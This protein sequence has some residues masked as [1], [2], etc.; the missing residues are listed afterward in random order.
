MKLLRENIL[1]VVLAAIV[2]LGGGGMVAAY[3]KTSGSVD[4]GVRKRVQMV[5]QLRDLS[6]DG[7]NGEMVERAEKSLENIRTAAKDV[8]TLCVGWNRRNYQV[9]QLRIPDSDQTVP[10]FPYDNETYRDHGLGYV[11]SRVYV[12]AMQDLLNSLNPTSPPTQA[13]TESQVLQWEN[14]LMLQR[15]MEA[16]GVDSWGGASGAVPP[17][18]A[19]QA[20]V[21]GRRSAM[22]NKAK[23]GEVYVDPN[24]LDMVF[25]DAVLNPM[26]DQLWQAQLNLWVTRDIVAAINATNKEAFASAE[27]Q[28][29]GRNVLTAAVKRLVQVRVNENYV[30]PSVQTEAVAAPTDGGAYP[31]EAP[32]IEAPDIGAR[33]TGAGPDA[34]AAADPL[35][36]RGSSR[37]YDVLHY[38]FS[39]VMPT[40]YL[41]ALERNL[42]AQNYHTILKVEFRPPGAG[43]GPYGMEVSETGGQAGSCYYGV[44]PV[45]QVDI[46][47]ELLLLTAW[48]RGTWDSEKQKFSDQ[49]PPLVPAE[50]LARQFPGADNPALREVD[51]SRLP[52]EPAPEYGYGGDYTER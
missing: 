21:L 42:M 29:S 51:T 19:Q 37:E 43:T 45:V 40:R 23:A 50:V 6:R 31:G 41:L 48:E 33:P 46:T 44:E 32:D 20:M 24:A 26:V 39:V 36:G 28:D 13:E 38:Q 49:F 7:A 10:A 27:G 16:A 4:E 25:R 1:L 22:L 2:L 14:Q 15:T 18:I 52:R 35:T 11:F 12:Q 3:F 8:E 34:P 9:L 17:D 5:R 47:G 30:R